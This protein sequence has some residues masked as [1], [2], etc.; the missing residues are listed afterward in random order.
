MLDG[1]DGASYSTGAVGEEN[2]PSAR[3]PDSDFD[4]LL[5]S[6]VDGAEE[7]DGGTFGK[8]GG[9]LLMPLGALR[10]LRWA[11]STTGEERKGVRGTLGVY[12]TC[13]EPLACPN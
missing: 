4:D 3:S 10:L 12:A 1:Q 9:S 8:A 5:A 11:L 6:Y 13:P 7:G 2:L